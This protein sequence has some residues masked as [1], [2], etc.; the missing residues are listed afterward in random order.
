MII[1]ISIPTTRTLEQEYHANKMK[2][3]LQLAKKKPAR[4]LPKNDRK[5]REKR[6]STKKLVRV[7][8][9]SKKGFLLSMR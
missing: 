3:F 1:G 6:K 4:N 8:S 2:L 5:K 7:V 9:F